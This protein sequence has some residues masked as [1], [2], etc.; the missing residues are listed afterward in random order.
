MSNGYGARGAFRTFGLAWA[1]GI[2]L[3]VA[4]VVMSATQDI[5]I[6]EPD[7]VL[8]SY[9]TFPGV[10]GLAIL[11]DVLPRLLHRAG[12]RRA[13]APRQL[14]PVAREVMAERWPAS[15]WWFALIGLG[16]WYLSYA[17]FRNVKSMAPLVNPERFDDELADF[18]R[19]LF[20]GHDPAAVLHSW[21]GESVTAHFL[22][23]VYIVWIAL[24]PVSIAIALV[25]TR[26]IQA[27]AWYV[28]AVAVDWCLGA[29]IY[30]LVP[31]VGPIYSD[32]GMF[33]GLP[34]T[35]VSDLQET[36]L[37]DRLAVLADPSGADRL[38]TVAAFAS[39]HVGIMVT[40]CLVVELVALPLWVRIVSWA[41]LFL[42]IL[43]TVY[44]GWHFAADVLGGAAM[45]AFAV[46][47]AGMATGNRVGWRVRLKRES[48]G[49]PSSGHPE[50][51][52]SRSAPLPDHPVAD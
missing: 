38:Q 11:I 15:H 37:T 19:F 41:F 35:Y 9:I 3:A 23:G 39:L 32:P 33:S 6:R 4:A 48:E 17:A 26:H 52:V 30:V 50:A 36:L 27:G 8:P 12:Q 29:L 46:W 5:P 2:T 49:S 14:G 16:A 20:L 28:T 42:T 45:G 22:S 21:L 13:W 51:L 34:H 31:T 47:L 10:L 18:D 7:G 44:L 43:S 25:W 1:A 24:V 40:I